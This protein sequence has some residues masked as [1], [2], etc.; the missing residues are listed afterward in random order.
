MN[1]FSRN[2]FVIM[3]VF[4]KKIACLSLFN[5]QLSVLGL[6]DRKREQTD[7]V[8][9]KLSTTDKILRWML[10]PCYRSRVQALTF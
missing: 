3:Y 7:T 1:I 4:L 2:P 6:I 10:G 9:D 5:G 8:N